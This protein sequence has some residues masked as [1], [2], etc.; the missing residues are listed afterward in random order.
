MAKNKSKNSMLNMIWGLLT[1]AGLVLLIMPT[2]LSIFVRNV[3]TAIGGGTAAEYGLFADFSMYDSGALATVVSVLLVIGLALAAIYLILYVIDTF[4]KTKMDFSKIRMFIAFIML[5]LFVATL[6]CGLVFASQ[7]VSGGID[8]VATTKLMCGV[9]FWL[10][11]AGM[12]VTSLFGYL[13]A[14]K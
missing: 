11:I 8:G 9:G 12:L 13:A 2:F 14:K 3:D 4:A 5:A 6:V 7:A 10:G 1:L